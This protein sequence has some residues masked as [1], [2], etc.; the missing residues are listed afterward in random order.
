MFVVIVEGSIGVKVD[1]LY[2]RDYEAALKSATTLKATHPSKTVK[3][4]EIRP[5]VEVEVTTSVKEL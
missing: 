4:A 5:V 1:T 3:V 2:A